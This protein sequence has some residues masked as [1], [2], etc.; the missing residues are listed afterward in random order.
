MNG[1]LPVDYTVRKQYFTLKVEFYSPVKDM[2]TLS[3]APRQTPFLAFFPPSLILSRN[4]KV[5]LGI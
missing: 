1:D 5:G 3:T 2:P 4:L